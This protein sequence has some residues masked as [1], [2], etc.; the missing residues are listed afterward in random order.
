[1]KSTETQALIWHGARSSGRD[2]A[3]R[4]SKLI[5]RTLPQSDSN[6]NS[7]TPG[8]YCLEAFGMEHFFTLDRLSREQQEI[9]K[10]YLE[11]LRVPAMSAGIYALPKGGEDL[12]SP[13]Q[14]DEI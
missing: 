14:E 13:H 3:C 9:A 2:A 6:D 10:P 12:Q 5:R 1:M 8:A 7:L 4:V 11:F